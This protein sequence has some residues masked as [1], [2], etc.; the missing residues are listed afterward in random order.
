M[1]YR[2]NFPNGKAARMCAA[3]WELYR[4]WMA[5]TW[6]DDDPF[7][8]DEGRAYWQHRDNCQDCTP[9]KVVNDDKQ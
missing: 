9:R 2:G 6:P 8:N 7:D 4:A 3:A 5:S 1:T